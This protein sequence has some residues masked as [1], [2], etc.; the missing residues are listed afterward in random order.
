MR[1]DAEQLRSAVIILSS[2]ICYL[3]PVID[4]NT[5]GK[6]RRGI[7]VY[8][9]VCGSVVFFLSSCLAAASEYLPA[10]VSDVLPENFLSLVLITGFSVLLELLSERLGFGRFG[11]VIYLSAV[12]LGLLLT[13]EETSGFWEVVRRSAL[14]CGYFI[15]GVLLFSRIRTRLDESESCEAF[16]GLP[17]ILLS[18]AFLSIALSGILNVWQNL[19]R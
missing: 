2:V 1:Y 4:G 14:Y 15:P 8:V 9:G 11:F 5:C 18:G 13:G 3:I 19:F 7:S 17:V 12:V 6:R 16:A 10:E